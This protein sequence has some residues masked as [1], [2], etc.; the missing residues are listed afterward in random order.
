MFVEPLGGK[1]VKS[2]ATEQYPQAGKEVMD[3]HN[4]HTL[5]SHYESFTAEEAFAIAQK[6]GNH[7]PPKKAVG[8]LLR[9][10]N[11]AP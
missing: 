8:L 1:E 6:L 10:L 11:R 5:S 3:N 7:Y 2:I 4:T 9:K